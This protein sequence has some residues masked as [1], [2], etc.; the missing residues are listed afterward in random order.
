MK[1]LLAAPVKT[2]P[3]LDK[4][5][6]PM[7]ASPKLDGI[8][9]LLHSELGPVS[10]KLKPIPNRFVR[11]VL[12]GLKLPCAD[13]ELIVGQAT[14]SDVFNTT[15]SAVMSHEGEPAF[16]YFVFDTFDKPAD[17]YG[18]RLQ[19][20]TAAA[21]ALDH[22][23]VVVL[24][25]SIVQNVAELVNLESA[26][27]AL[28]FEGIMLRSIHGPYKFGRSTFNE[29]TLLKLKVFT[30]AEAEV[31]GVEELLRNDN[32]ATQ[33]ELGHTKRSSHAE[34]KTPMNTLGAL[35]VKGKGWEQTFKIGT[36]FDAAMRK[37]LWGMGPELI[38][39]LVKFKFQDIGVK[40]RPRFP[41]FLG[42][43]HPDDMS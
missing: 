32:E 41:V 1:P 7:I 33:D 15:S 14:A 4:L 23:A 25:H 43:R 40:D 11:S 42:L 10:R 35:V 9:T 18:D 17:S 31:I 30:D 29:Q 12:A 38:G 39:Q 5:Q 19:R 8:R 22:S 20:I 16:R 24:E 21:H 3:D 13:G 37:K 28:G 27:L 2:R 26:W 34:N 36:G 6:F